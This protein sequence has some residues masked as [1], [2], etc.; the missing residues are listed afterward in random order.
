MIKGRLKRILSFR[1]PLF[2]LELVKRAEINQ[3]I[4]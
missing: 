4:F 3:T 2:Y 1:R